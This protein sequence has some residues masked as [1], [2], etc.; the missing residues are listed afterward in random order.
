MRY[1]QRTDRCWYD[2]GTNAFLAELPP[3]AKSDDVDVTPLLASKKRAAIG[4]LNGACAIRITGGIT[5]SVLGSPHRYDTEEH[6]QLNMLGLLQNGVQQYDFPCA[7]ANGVKADRTHM[8]AQLKAVRDA[9]IG[10]K[11]ELLKINRLAKAAVES[12]DTAEGVRAALRNG[13][14]AMAAVSSTVSS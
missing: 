13:L 14:S 6:D 1:E 4:E 7:D 10:F 9:F 8:A 5:L 11:G 12:A 2:L 3:N